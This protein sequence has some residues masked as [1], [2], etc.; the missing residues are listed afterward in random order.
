MKRERLYWQVPEPG[1]LRLALYLAR[2]THKP[3]KSQQIK[4]FINRYTKTH[5]KIAKTLKCVK[6]KMYHSVKKSNRLR[7]YVLIIEFNHSVGQPC[8]LPL[9]IY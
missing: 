2:E 8:L 1:V 6:E 3:K 9:D 4:E 7:A 5:K